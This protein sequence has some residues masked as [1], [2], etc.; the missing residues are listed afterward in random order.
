LPELLQLTPEQIYILNEE[1]QDHTPKFKKAISRRLH[2]M[3]LTKLGI[4]V[5]DCSTRWR[6]HRKAGGRIIKE[7]LNPCHEPC[8]CEN[9]A[10][11]RFE[12]EVE[13]Y[14]VLETIIGDSFVLLTTAASAVSI[15][16]ILRRLG[17]MLSKYCWNP[18]EKRF[19]TRILFTKSEHAI[20]YQVLQAIR[21]LDPHIRIRPYAAS[22]FKNVLNAM[23][24]PTLPDFDK[25]LVLKN[26]KRKLIFE[27]MNWAGRKLLFDNK[28]QSLS[29]KNNKK[30]HKNGWCR[31]KDCV[32]HTEPYWIGTPEHLLWWYHA[33]APPVEQAA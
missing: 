18:R 15:R 16:K 9:C 7:N 13:R 33:P 8:L 23:L 27:G 17:P 1:I 20:S 21:K 28:N 26:I 30:V 29:N 5:D 19:E 6:T 25:Q 4:H 2:E 24:M 31:V 32:A 3:G 22:R 11:L 14:G 10:Q 12:D